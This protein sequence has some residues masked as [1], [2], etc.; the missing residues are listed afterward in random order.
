MVSYCLGVITIFEY[1]YSHPCILNP[2]RVYRFLFVWCFVSKC[3]H[4]ALRNWLIITC[5][6]KAVLS[7]FKLNSFN[8]C[9]PKFF[10][11]SNRCIFTHRLR[12][13]SNDVCFP[14]TYLH[15]QVDG[16]CL[17]TQ[18]V[19]STRFL[20]RHWLSELNYPTLDVGSS[21]FHIPTMLQYPLSDLTHLRLKH[22]LLRKLLLLRNK[23]NPFHIT[24]CFQSFIWRV[25][26]TAMEIFFF[27]AFS[28]FVL[29]WDK[30]HIFSSIFHFQVLSLGRLFV[31]GV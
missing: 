24:F 3:L 16:E 22:N 8:L 23:V 5:F 28:L 26:W 4:P 31:V 11:Y 30:V 19:L 2:Y 14:G 7:I 17:K 13:V 9:F 18:T 29:R 6:L 21:F 27:N 10:I 12:F 15:P 1:L 20:V 25:I